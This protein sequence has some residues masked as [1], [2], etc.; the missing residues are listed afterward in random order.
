MYVP[1][2]RVLLERLL[3]QIPPNLQLGRAHDM[4]HTKLLKEFPEVVGVTGREWS[5]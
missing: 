2:V 5:C 3:I 4:L 1:T